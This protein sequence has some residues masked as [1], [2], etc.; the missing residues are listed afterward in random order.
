ME[1]FKLWYCALPETKRN[2]FHK[3]LADF[4]NEE[5]LQVKP[6]RSVRDNRTDETIRSNI[7]DAF[8]P[9]IKD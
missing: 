1:D 6:G 9:E 7:S 3:L 5:M 4:I 8:S 2:D